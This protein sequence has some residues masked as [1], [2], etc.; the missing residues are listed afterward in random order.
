MNN[1]EKILKKLIKKI[2]FNKVLRVFSK[3]PNILK[4]WERNF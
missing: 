3:S 4:K 1:L 2:D